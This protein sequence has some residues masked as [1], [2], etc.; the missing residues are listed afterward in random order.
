VLPYQSELISSELCQNSLITRIQ[1]RQGRAL[2]L[3]HMLED[4]NL[5]EK[6]L[7]AGCPV[8]RGENWII[9]F[10]VWDPEAFL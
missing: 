10:H 8:S 4:G 9:E 1:P 2:I 6:A 3:Y 7:H 5:D